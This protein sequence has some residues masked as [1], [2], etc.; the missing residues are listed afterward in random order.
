[1]W[2]VACSERTLS[3]L[4]TNLKSGSVPHAYLISGPQKVGKSTLA[5]N[6]AQAVNCSSGDRP[7]GKCASCIKI[8][9]GKHSDIAHVSVAKDKTEIGM[10]QI[11]DVQRSASLKPFEGQFRVII[12]NNADQ[13]STEAANRLL[14]TLEEPPDQVLFIL[15]TS[16][17]EDMLQT[18]ISRC[19]LIEMEKPQASSIAALLEKTHGQESSRAEYLAR[20]SRGAVGWA[21]DCCTNDRL[22]AKR[23]ETLRELLR[24]EKESWDERLAFAAELA[25]G[26]SKNREELYD[27][28]SLW[29]SVWR[30]IVQIRSGEI[31]QI[32][33]VDVETELKLSAPAY[34]DTACITAIRCLEETWLKLEQNANARL[35]LEVLILSLPWPPATS[36][37]SN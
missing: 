2:N 3:I 13:L 35:A 23:E 24:L 21:V 6:I 37:T 12:I 19:A 36:S 18:I 5:L 30:D 33:N 9:Q 17:T 29:Q 11:K 34:D 1:M 16:K 26:Y 15:T 10:E 14:K 7:C 27:T 20:I 28:L 22:L 4:D 8:A 25:S 31:G 32:F